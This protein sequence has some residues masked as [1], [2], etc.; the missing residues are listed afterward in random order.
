M[1]NKY[2]IIDIDKDTNYDEWLNFRLS[3]I[4]ASEIGT[5]LG[6]NPYKSSTE[7]F[8]QKLKMIPIKQ[9][10]NMAMFFGN[11]LES[12]VANMWEYYDGTPESL[13][14]N[15]NEDKRLRCAKPIPG[16]VLN[17]E[18]PHMFFSPDRVIV[19]DPDEPVVKTVKGEFQLIHD[20]IDGILEI[21]TI[22]GF[23]S[24][25]W[26]SGLPP[27]YVIQLT[28]YMMGL[29]CSY[30]EIALLEDGR[31][32]WTVR[33]DRSATL[34]RQIIEATQEFTDRVNAAKSDMPNVQLY[35]PEPDGTQAY[36][37]F[38]NKRYANSEAKTLVG[39]DEMYTLAMAHK[40]EM[41]HM[42]ILEGNVREYSNAIKAIMKEHEM[43]DFGS[44]GKIVWRTDARGIRSLRN[45]IK[46]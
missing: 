29:D 36:E 32:L 38:V 17:S 6:L 31:N 2:T 10:E 21:K 22:S 5:I 12:F 39:D 28:A 26:E 4:G 25:Q 40:Q 14:T 8:Y 35:E 45:Q 43:L 34:E 33:I 3:G 46:E 7:L 44:R 16:Y 24:K 11:R 37:Q 20:N 23:A 15:F 9:E 18:Y 42:K 13:I 41:E 27:S 30:G 19:K 1:K